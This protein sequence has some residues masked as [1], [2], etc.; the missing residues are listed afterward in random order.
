MNADF[1]Y[2]EATDCET[3]EVFQLK[4]VEV[5]EFD[6]G[7][8]VKN[9]F[10]FSTDIYLDT[11]MSNMLPNGHCVT[12][13][14]LNYMEDYIDVEN[15]VVIAAGSVKFTGTCNECGKIG[16]G[17]MDENGNRYYPENWDDLK[18]YE[19]ID[20]TFSID[21]GEPIKGSVITYK[22]YSE[23]RNGIAEILEYKCKEEVC[24]TKEKEPMA[25]IRR[26]VK[27]G[28]HVKKC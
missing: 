28:I 26:S 19:G 11:T 3:G 23:D 21:G 1:K 10:N 13:R 6:N 20:I 12:L 4:C 17:L 9:E 7:E 25:N 18:K 16:Y 24:D 15:L 5:G 14:Q 2:Y 22:Y 8:F 27:P